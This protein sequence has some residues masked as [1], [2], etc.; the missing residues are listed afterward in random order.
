MVIRHSR[1]SILSILAIHVKILFRAYAFG[2]VAG[3]NARAPRISP[4][5][6]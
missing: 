3:E 6:A 5:F 2:L 4:A 1:S